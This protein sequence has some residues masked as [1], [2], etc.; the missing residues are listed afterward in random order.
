M[1]PNLAQLIN[2]FAIKS[3]CENDTELSK[4]GI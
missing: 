3:V 2:W 1:I 4:G